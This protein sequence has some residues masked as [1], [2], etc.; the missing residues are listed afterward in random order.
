MA[1]RS[2]N[3][4]RLYFVSERPGG[5]G[6]VDIWVAD[7]MPDGRYGDARNVT[8][9]NSEHG[10]SDIYVDPDERFMIFHRSVDAT[11]SVEFWIAFGTAGDW[12]APRPLEEVNG[13]GW[14]L[15]P[16]VS[17][18]GRYFF[19]NRDGVIQQV[20]FCQLIR[21]DERTFLSSARGRDLACSRP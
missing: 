20:D 13:P 11:G 18:D 2:T 17:P 1:T 19:F 10:D 6:G 5:R 9:L 12:R 8:T 21:A 3:S 4:G 15:S 16:T 14:E 7:P